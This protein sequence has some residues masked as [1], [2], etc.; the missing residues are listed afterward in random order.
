MAKSEPVLLSA[1]VPAIKELTKNETPEQRQARAERYTHAFA[2][3]D[4]A[5][6]EHVKNW[7]AAFHTYKTNS[8]KALEQKLATVEDANIASL[9]Q[10]F[11]S[12]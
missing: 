3:Y 8:M 7:N 4:T 6:A 9:E 2:L 10:S 12:A 1:N 11:Q 5:F